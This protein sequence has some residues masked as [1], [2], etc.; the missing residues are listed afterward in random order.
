MIMNNEH[1]Q[2]KVLGK[3]TQFYLGQGSVDVI[4]RKLD[5][6]DLSFRSASCCAFYTVPRADALRSEP[7]GFVVPLVAVGFGEELSQDAVLV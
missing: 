4:L 5:G 7:P 2:Q 1:G 3:G 6:R